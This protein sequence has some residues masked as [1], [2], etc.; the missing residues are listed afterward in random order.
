M[1]QG[2]CRKMCPQVEYINRMKGRRLAA[3]EKDGN[4]CVSEFVRPGVGQ[5]VNAGEIRTGKTLKRTT[6]YLLGM[7]VKYFFLFLCFIA[8]GQ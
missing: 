7:K 3:F 5:V 2:T 4:T 6:D 1:V 8:Q